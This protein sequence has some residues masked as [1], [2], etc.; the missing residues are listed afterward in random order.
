MSTVS[1]L[2]RVSFYITLALLKSGIPHHPASRKSVGKIPFFTSWLAVTF[3]KLGVNS[4]VQNLLPTEREKRHTKY[5]PLCFDNNMKFLSTLIS[6]VSILGVTTA[7]APHSSF[8]VQR[9]AP[10]SSTAAYDGIMTSKFFYLRI[11][12]SKNPL[13]LF[14]VVVNR[15]RQ[16]FSSFFEMTF[17]LNISSLLFQSSLFFLKKIWS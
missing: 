11:F 10:V 8:G 7:F 4:L 15:N 12:L 6:V 3:Q 2:V 14:V 5:F 16:I 9:S 1:F 13:F 17:F